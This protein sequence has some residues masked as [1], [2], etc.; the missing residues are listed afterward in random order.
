MKTS[1]L[2]KTGSRYPVNRKKI[3]HTVNQFLQKTGLAGW[4]V[5]LTFVGER[6]IKQLAQKHLGHQE[7]HVVLA[8]PLEVAETKIPFP[9]ISEGKSVLGEIVI[10][11]PQARQLAQAKNTMVDDIINSLVEYG[12]GHLIGQNPNWKLSN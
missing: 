12:L 8:F 6:Q 10:S 5:S 3:R 4:Q 11:Y 2:I 7:E 9:L 1:V